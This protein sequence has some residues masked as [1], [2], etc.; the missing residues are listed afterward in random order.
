MHRAFPSGLERL[1]LWAARKLVAARPGSRAAVWLVPRDHPWREFFVSQS[2]AVDE[3]TAVALRPRMRL[4]LDRRRRD[5][6]RIAF[7]WALTYLAV[8][9]FVTVL[10]GLG[11]VDDPVAPLHSAGL[12]DQPVHVPSLPELTMMML[13]AVPL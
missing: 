4:E 6:R 1:R 11:L 3:L 13:G 2:E 8:A 12:S 10:P 7:G 9:D 5:N